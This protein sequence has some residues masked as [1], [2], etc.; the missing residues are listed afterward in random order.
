MTKSATEAR[1]PN[2]MPLTQPNSATLALLPHYPRWCVRANL[3]GGVAFLFTKAAPSRH[4]VIVKGLR[5]MCIAV[6][7]VRTRAPKR[8][9]FIQTSE[10][11]A[12][13]E[14]IQLEPRRHAPRAAM[15]GVCIVC[16]PSRGS[17]YPQQLDCFANIIHDTYS[18]IL[19]GITY[20]CLTE[21]AHTHSFLCAHVPQH[22]QQASLSLS[23]EGEADTGPS[24]SIPAH[25]QPMP[26]GE[27]DS[28]RLRLLAGMAGIIASI[29]APPTTKGTQR[30]NVGPYALE[31]L[32][33]YAASLG[34]KVKIPANPSQFI[35]KWSTRLCESFD[36]HDL[37][38]P[39]R[40]PKVPTDQL[41][42]AV[43]YVIDTEPTAQHEM[44]SHAGFKAIMDK[45]K[46]TLGTMWQG[47]MKVEPGLGRYI[48]VDFKKDLSP[49]DLSQRVTISCRWTVLGINRSAPGVSKCHLGDDDDDDGEWLQPPP[50]KTP[51]YKQPWLTDWAR[52]IIFI[53]AKKVY[54]V[55]QSYMVY[56]I[57]GTPSRVVE[58]PRVMSKAW[59]IHYYSAVNYHTG[60]LLLQLVT[61]TQGP[62]YT[63]AKKYQVG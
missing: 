30:H 43:Q 39:G 29:E 45:Y 12:W 17:W 50:P 14:Q 52:C 54:I 16:F 20:A 36:V 25:P 57:K 18:I 15:Y 40:D 19:G 55:P 1:P 38:T 8:R 32:K 41:Q 23:M 51:M 47:M 28:K 48:R 21:N 3:Y 63:P 35:K 61:G 59:V 11:D 60:G 4:A 24:G 10:G 9:A 37:P 22:H 42:Q 31:L 53:D 49:A 7:G 62:G 27:R 2:D 56:G 34:W 33:S 26:E 58:D 44:L 5:V 13:D 46:V 6:R